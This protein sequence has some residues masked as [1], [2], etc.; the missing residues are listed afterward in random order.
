MPPEPY[1][2]FT[3]S[4]LSFVAFL[5]TSHS[6]FFNFFLIF[7]IQRC[8]TTRSFLWLL[9]PPWTWVT[10]WLDTLC[11][12]W[13]C[14]FLAVHLWDSNTVYQVEWLCLG[15]PWRYNRNK[16]LQTPSQKFTFDNMKM[17]IL[18]ENCFNSSWN[19]VLLDK[20]VCTM[21]C[22]CVCVCVCVS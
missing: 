13:V 18:A 15:K 3:W 7:W 20:C 12:W 6:L 16:Y 2:S 14:F 4:V 21:S 11:C 8:S 22:T 9:W 10:Q 17:D 1:S 5:S 19:I